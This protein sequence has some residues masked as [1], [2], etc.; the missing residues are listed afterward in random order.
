MMQIPLFTSPIS[1]GFPHTVTA[2]IDDCLDLNQLVVK[3]PT[4]TYFVRVDGDSM[5]K[6]D[7]DNGDI[8]VVDK[9]LEPKN[10]DIVIAF[11]NGKALV[12][13]FLKSA[14]NIYLIPEND[15]YSSIQVGG[16]DEFEIWGIVTYVVHKV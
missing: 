10:Y 14:M 7:I 6:A 3:H 5:I 16:S 13:R 4:S 8:L 9:S 12:K 15:K 1:A 2:D 11:L